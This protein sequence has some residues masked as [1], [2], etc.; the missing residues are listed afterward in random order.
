MTRYRWQILIAVLGVVI[1]LLILVVQ[2]SPGIHPAAVASQEPRGGKY[3][4]ALVGHLQRLNPLL[5][6]GNQVDRDVD[7]L[8][9]SGLVGFDAQGRPVPDLAQG[10]VISQ[11]ALTYT[12]ILR[13]DARWQDGTP[14]TTQDVLFTF[15]LM[16]DA[17][18]SGPADLAQMWRQIKIQAQDDST[19][20]FK[21]P[22]P[23]A[24]F[25]DYLSEGLLPAHALAGVKAQDLANQTFNIAPVGTGPFR[26][27]HL[28]SSQN[29]ITGVVLA[30]SASYYG[31]KPQ[32]SEVDFF[33][34]G[35]LDA[36]FQALRTGQVMG[37]GGL[38]PPMVEEAL[39]LPNLQ[40]FS[41]RLPD[42]SLVLLNLKNDGDPFFGQR[43]VRE[44]LLLS[45]NRENIINT[46]LAGQAFPAASPI[47]PGTWTANPA[48]APA[49]YDPG[50]SAQLL[51]A[52]GWQLP[53]S[54]T[55]GTDAYV[56]A[57]NSKALQFTL[58]YPEDQ[59]HGR[60]AQLIQAQWAAV[61]ARVALKAVSGTALLKDYLQPRSYDAALVDFDL[62]RFPDPDP[63]PF[64]HQTQAT[65]GQNYSQLDDRTISEP[66][67]TARTDP[68]P[69]TRARLYWTFQDRFAYEVP[70]V[71]LWYPTYTYALDLSVKGVSLGPLTDPSDRL[72]TLRQW[73]LA[74]AH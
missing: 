35:S 24:P 65:T 46:A 22:E 5:D 47:L 33:Y 38:S 74:S 15:G 48:L 26:L 1:I 60:V 34:F 19:V 45:L 17:N 61:G 39:Q 57:K 32:L 68:D 63:Y 64:W 6:S 36:A 55:P 14:V 41:S 66:L 51:D 9:Y 28:I 18:Y 54:A 13:K 30:P 8:I 25:V 37:L 21:L 52:A 42:L 43:E 70:A 73:H 50:Q 53:T 44:A 71:L 10:W 58:V 29:Q 11:D 3:A 16:Q 72:S 27:D 59:F 56:R 4:E 20:S 7:R 49:P 40:L 67:E 69:A 31:P 2:K 62:S 12:V 23:Y